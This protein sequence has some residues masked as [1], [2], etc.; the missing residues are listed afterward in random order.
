MASSDALSL[1]L[2]RSMS[3]A[4]WLIAQFGPAEHYFPFSSQWSFVLTCQFPCASVRITAPCSAQGVGD[5]VL[6]VRFL[7]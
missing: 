4:L 6:I 3:I 2:R 5:L 1:V 7:S